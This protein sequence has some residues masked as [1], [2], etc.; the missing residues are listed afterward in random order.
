MGRLDGVTETDRL[1]YHA[2]ARMTGVVERKRHR[3]RINHRT[4]V[5]PVANTRIVP[6]S[7]GDTP[8]SVMLTATPV[9]VSYMNRRYRDVSVSVRLRNL[10]DL[11]IWIRR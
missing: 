4:M 6:T 1:E 11:A 7:K 2:H 10:S 8:P 9:Q 5:P 3:M